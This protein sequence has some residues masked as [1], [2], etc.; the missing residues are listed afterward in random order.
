MKKN[1]LVFWTSTVYLCIFIILFGIELGLGNIFL[2]FYT[3]IFVMF[4]T[5]CIVF[6]YFHM[7]YNLT[8]KD[9]E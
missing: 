3:L 4:E 7:E 2:V 1:E 9:N 8:R 6:W 5:W